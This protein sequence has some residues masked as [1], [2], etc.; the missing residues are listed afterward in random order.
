MAH[1]VIEPERPF[2]HGSFSRD[3]AP[4]LTIDP[5][6]TVQYRTLDAGWNIR[7]AMSDDDTPLKF[8]PRDPE[9]DSG[10]SM[11]G[12]IAIRG[13]R[14]GMT[15]EVRIDEVRPG[16]YGWTAAGGWDCPA[17]RRLGVVDTSAAHHWRLDADVLTAVNQ[18]GHTIRLRP[19]MG[20]M[21]MP[22]DEP[23]IH[24][25]VPP[26]STGGNIDCKELVA[27]SR[28]FLPI[29]VEGALF[30][31]GDGHAA[32]GDGEEST[33]AV[34]S[35][36]DRVVL[37]FHLHEDLRITTPRAES[38]VGWMTLG[39]NED[40]DEAAFVAT[41]AMLDLMMELH[42]LKRLDALAL[43]SLVVDLRVT[44]MVNR[45]RGVHAV[46]PHDVITRPSV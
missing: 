33:T 5:G 14:P 19:F 24:S 44:Q 21:G 20:V 41:E 42:S 37:T 34:E 6:D 4:C 11:C 2:L 18:H 25:T 35:P 29:A 45:V 46:L 13:A 31:V 32:Q 36:M 40:L 1:H 43:A 15:L 16:P 38:S 26:R 3:Y 28:L 17:N 9:R 23:G 12:P 22:P 8:E 7:P 30:S 39:F 10:H 27:G